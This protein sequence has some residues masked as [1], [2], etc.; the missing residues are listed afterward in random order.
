M[1]STGPAA[2][3]ATTPVFVTVATLALDVTHVACDVT[4][5]TEPLDIVADAAN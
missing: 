3:P 1:M 4:A 5:W 2:I